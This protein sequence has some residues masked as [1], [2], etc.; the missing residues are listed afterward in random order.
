MEYT[1]PFSK[2]DQDDL[3]SVG[4]VGAKWG[5]LVRAGMPV[6]PGFVVTA[7]A[8]WEFLDKSGLSDK[9]HHL[10]QNLNAGNSKS[11]EEA[12]VLIRRAV[13][14]SPIPKILESEINDEYRKLVQGK[15]VPVRVSTS[16]TSSGGMEERFG[17]GASFNEVL[18]QVRQAWAAGF[19]PVEIASSSAKKINHSK[20][21]MGVVVH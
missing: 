7:E 11:L 13:V 12:S 21:G 14:R 18:R 1:L 5:D 16:S 8:Y 15:K 3:S 19:S 6:Q 4:S 2:I 10:L 9:I 20:V 17:S